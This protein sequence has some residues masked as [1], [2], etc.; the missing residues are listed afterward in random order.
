MRVRAGLLGEEEFLNKTGM[1]GGVMI[2]GMRRGKWT[3]LF[4]THSILK[5][6]AGQLSEE[7]GVRI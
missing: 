6:K 1:A 5:H 2:C 3:D 4:W 7:Y